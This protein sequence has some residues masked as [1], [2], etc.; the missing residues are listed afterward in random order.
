LLKLL[1]IFII[2]VKSFIKNEV[3]DKN[4]YIKEIILLNL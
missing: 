2:F 3:V 4:F 1:N